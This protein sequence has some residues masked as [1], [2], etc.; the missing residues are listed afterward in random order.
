[1]EERRRMPRKYLIIY[2]R[3]FNRGSGQLLGY[4]ADMSPVGAMVISDDSLPPETLIPLRIDLPPNEQFSVDHIDLMAR[5]A[6]CQPDLDPSFHNIGL[7]FLEPNEEQRQVI[8]VM[9]AEYEFR[10]EL[11][12]YP[13]SPS[14]LDRGDSIN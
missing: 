10:R 4:L 7:E 1:M 3:V 13:A 9:I 6:W 11:P 2:S 5:V 12:D 14:V 8:L